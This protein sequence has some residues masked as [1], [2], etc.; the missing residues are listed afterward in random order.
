MREYFFKINKQVLFNCLFASIFSKKY[1]LQNTCATDRC[2]KVRQSSTFWVHS[3]RF[4]THPRGIYSVVCWFVGLDVEVLLNLGAC[5][6]E[7][8]VWG[9]ICAGASRTTWLFSWK[10]IGFGGKFDEY[11]TFY[12]LKADIFKGV[13]LFLFGIV[14]QKILPSSIHNSS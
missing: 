4:D 2:V 10:I 8:V 1:H 12:L 13:T 6:V 14:S 5:V 9:I 3:E 11:W 7:V